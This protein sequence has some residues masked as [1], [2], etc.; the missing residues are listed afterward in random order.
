M[1]G[2]KQILERA[3]ANLDK[4]ES[5]FTNKKGKEVKYS[6]KAISE[7]NAKLLRDYAEH[8]EALPSCKSYNRIIT[9]LYRMK[10]IALMIN[11]NLDEL[12]EHDLR[13]FNIKLKQRGIETSADYRSGLKKFLKMLD[14]RKYIDLLDS[15]Y[16]SEAGTHEDRDL[17][18]ANTFFN[19]E[20]CERYLDESKRYSIR[21]QCFAALW[22]TTALRPQEHR[23]LTKSMIERKPD[24]LIIRVP[25]VKTKPRIIVLTGGEANAVWNNISPYLTE[26]SPDEKLFSMTWAGL[27]KSHRVICKKANISSK[28]DLGLYMSR[29]MILSRWYNEFGLAKASQMAGHIPGSKVMKHYVHLTETQL[30]EGKTQVR[31]STK[32][33]P[34]PLC[35]FDNEAHLTQCSKCGSPLDRQVFASIMEKN[36]DDRIKAQL[37]LIDKEALIQLLTI[38]ANK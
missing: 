38:K 2:N 31:I 14:K 26:L 11:S 32:Q 16:L 24:Q 21:Q 6:N 20:E 22:L 17:V 12:T 29:K 30:L 33:C 23:A 1:E 25:K 19:Q 3:L 15:D 13:T 35:D 9:A 4:P 10:S 5:I 27:N 28:R 7:H 34:N 8:Y 36:V 37:Q 18:D